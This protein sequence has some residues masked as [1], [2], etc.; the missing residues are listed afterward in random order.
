MCVDTIAKLFTSGLSI[1]EV[2]RRT[3]QVFGTVRAHL[4]IAASGD[5]KIPLRTS[6][7]PYVTSNGNS[8]A[9]EKADHTLNC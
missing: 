4:I 5:S 3:G 9:A 2:T 8:S 1:R 7:P 6:N